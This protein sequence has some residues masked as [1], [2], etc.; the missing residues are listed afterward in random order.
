MRLNPTPSQRADQGRRGDAALVNIEEAARASALHQFVA[1][2]E[3][4]FTKRLPGMKYQAERWNFKEASGQFDKK[5]RAIDLRTL[6]SLKAVDVT[7]YLVK[8]ALAGLHPSFGEAAHALLALWVLESKVKGSW[9]FTVGLRTLRHLALPASGWQAD[10]PIWELRAEHLKFIERVEISRCLSSQN[11]AEL[12][13]QGLTFE[14]LVV[15]GVAQEGTSGGKALDTLLNLFRAVNELHKAK[16]VGAL[17]KRMSQ[18]TS[19]A[20]NR[21]LVLQRRRFKEVKGV[22]LGPSIQALSDAICAMADGDPRL[23]AIQQ[24]A[25]CVMGIEMCAPSRINEVLTLSIHDRLHDATAYDQAPQQQDVPESE[26]APE[27]ADGGGKAGQDARHAKKAVGLNEARL[28][29]QTHAAMKQA[30]LPTHDNALSNT[31]LMKG[32]KGAAWGAKPLMD[33][34]VVMFNECFD[35]LTDMGRRSR[36]LLAHYEQH[37]DRLYLPPDLEHLRGRPLSKVQVGRIML[38]DGDLGLDEEDYRRRCHKARSATR[39]TVWPKLSKAHAHTVRQ[40]PDWAAAVADDRERFTLATGCGLPDKDWNET[41]LTRY[42]EW[43]VLEAEL[44][45]Q[46]KAQI[47]S[48]P[49]VTQR[50]RYTGRLSNML[51]AFDHLDN[52]PPYLPGALSDENIRYRL[53]SCSQ[54]NYARLQ[55]VFEALE[56]QMPLRGT[57]GDDAKLVPAYCS[58]HDPRRWLTTMSLRHGGAELSRM[59]VNMWANRT[60]MNQLNAYDYRSGEERA[61]ATLQVIP[62]ALHSLGPSDLDEMIQEEM[63]SDYGLSARS[64]YAVIAG[65]RTLRLATMEAIHS[66]ELSHPSAKAGEQ[67]LIVYPTR[68]GVCLHQHHATPCTNHRGC[69]GACATQRIVKGHLPSNQRV[70]EREQQLF[71]V[72]CHVVRRTILARNREAVH[73]LDRIDAHLK[74]LIE[75]NMTVERLAQ[76]LIGEF[77]S[78]K[79]LIKDAVFRADLEDAFVYRKYVEILDDSTVP[80]GTPIRYLNRSRNGRPEF[81]RNLEALGGRAALEQQAL[82]AL[83]ENPW[84]ARRGSVNDEDPGEELTYDGSDDKGEDD[85]QDADEGEQ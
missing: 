43:S 1:E 48:L 66:A 40:R 55:T 25:L 42:I 10:A 8:E 77:E 2:T 73:D 70:R 68:F 17:P 36:M 4:R 83:E 38:L 81:E 63:I 23:S 56:I 64:G 51:M 49:W 9:E 62:P 21:I 57:K 7:L 60:D 33:F 79:D 22:E 71:E 11:T 46:V 72:I 34:M 31:V 52:T 5:G 84:M 19:L 74:A 12:S 20:L 37:P 24:A 54:G 65:L 76:M 6:H 16:V 27:P 3:A 28:L 14:G 53:K 82:Q 47:H 44:L 15:S 41:N 35:R 58:P 32:S 26:V 50:I 61:H 39:A 29:H 75:P 85:D 59:L 67:L 30:S 69:E 80:N 45:R 78:I 13:K 18:E